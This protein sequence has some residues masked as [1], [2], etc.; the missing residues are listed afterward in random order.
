MQV[1]HDGSCLHLR[2]FTC[3]DLDSVTNPLIRSTPADVARHS[4]FDIVVGRPGL[5]F[6]ES[7][8]LHDLT[9]LAV[10]ALRDLKLLPRTLHWMSTVFAQTF[11]GRDFFSRGSAH[12]GETASGGFPVDVHCAGAA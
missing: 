1:E 8:G 5:L 12:R 7:D 4:F 3:S 11:D 6:K 9:A 2:V 10:T